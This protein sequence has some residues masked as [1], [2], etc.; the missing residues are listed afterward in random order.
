MA[1][2]SKALLR[3]R[4]LL[5]RRAIAPRHKTA[6]DAAI[7]ARVL[8]WWD[9]NKPPMLGV[10][11]ALRGEPDLDAAYAELAARGARLALPVVVARDAPLGFAEW[12]PGE[13]MATD[14]MGVKV[15][16]DLRMVACPPALLV[17][18]LGF[19]DGNFRLGYGGGYYDRTLAAAPRTRTL[20][21]AYACM[22]AEF[23]S[24]PHDVAL[25]LVL[26]EAISP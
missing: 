7:G 23:A 21:I 20:G 5:A 14:Q 3:A 2:D 22:Q 15:P 17:P 13:A 26:T 9:A 1:N 12:R 25:D 4:L 16:A 6:W 10:Y 18:C 11:Q 8:D 19:N 24:A